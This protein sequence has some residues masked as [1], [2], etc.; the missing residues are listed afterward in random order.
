M[1]HSDWFP[2][3]SGGSAFQNPAQKAESKKREI[4]QRCST[5]VIG[6]W[7]I[8][9]LLVVGCGSSEIKPVDIFPEDNCAQCRMAVSDERF[10]SEIIN[11][12]GEAF[13]F[14]DLGCMLKFRAKQNDVKIAGIFLKD[15]ETKEWIPYER[16]TLIE[17]DVETPMGSGKLAF[18]DSIRAREFQK[19]HPAS[20]ALSEAG[21]GGG[22]CGEKKN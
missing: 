1:K 2:P 10:A 16:A 9:S 12:D 6:H 3:N 18:A 21:C 17:T 5:L 19:R 20:N 15:Y 7:I 8:I 13:K 22:C 4:S 14:D 11:E